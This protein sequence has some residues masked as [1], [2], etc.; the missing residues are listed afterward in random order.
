[1]DS[2]AQAATGA[3][4]GTIGRKWVRGVPGDA[5]AV[6]AARRVLDDRLR[7]VAELFADAS[8]TGDAKSVHQ[9]R[10][11]TRRAQAALEAFGP[12]MKRSIRRKTAREMRSIRR[13]AGAA[14]LCDAHLALFAEMLPDSPADRAAAI[15]FILGGLKSERR[16]GRE[17]I[18][19]ERA[20]RSGKALKRLRRGARDAVRAGRGEATFG[21]AGARAIGDSVERVRD[22]ASADL[23]VFEHLH[24][25]R[26]RIK[27][28][29][30]MLELF[31]GC[32][33][34]RSCESMYA[35]SSE[36]QRRLGRMNDAHEAHARAAGA[37][38]AEGA[39]EAILPGLRALC[40]HLDE[41]RRLTREAF[42]RWWT[43]EGAPAMGEENAWSPAPRERTAGTSR[44]PAQAEAEQA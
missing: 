39:P 3:E 41:Q 8:K 28:L 19:A 31:S 43:A 4:R 2:V 13:T 16:A 33:P 12:L 14:R 29:R 9:L 26:K 37:L 30:Y 23:S 11:A 34:E 38:E 27:S 20:A 17:A 21:E 10:V 22:A 44:R 7:R 15:G 6:E 42:L 25:L 1:M 24:T 40:V 36:A 18:V 5:C 32:L 35:L